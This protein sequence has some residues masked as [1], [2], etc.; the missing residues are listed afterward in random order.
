MDIRLELT[1]TLPLLMKNPRLADPDD[2]IVREIAKITAKGSRMSEDDRR[3]KERWQWLGGL[4]VYDGQI[5][6]PTANIRKCLIDSGKT[7]RKGSLVSSAVS[8]T[9]LFVPLAYE[10]PRDVD[11]LWKDPAFRHR[12]MVNANPNSSKKSM[13][14][15][16]RPRFLPWGLA[17]DLLLLENVMDLADLQYYAERAGQGIGL[18]DNRRNGY[19]RFTVTVKQL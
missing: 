11:E 5:V 10:G 8:F 13:V 6:M 17:V 14:P 3:A 19:G 1:G 16:V 15:S 9:D 7:G 4:Y 2:E 12:D 18:G